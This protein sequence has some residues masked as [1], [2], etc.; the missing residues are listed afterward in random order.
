MEGQVQLA[1]GKFWWTRHYNDMSVERR[2]F[3]GKGYK[4]F[5][6]TMLFLKNG[7]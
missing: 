6:N 7:T 4:P 3:D 1:K 5:L 2:A